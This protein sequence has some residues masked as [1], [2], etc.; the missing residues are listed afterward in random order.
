MNGHLQ[1][2]FYYFKLELTQ[3]K[4]HIRL[5]LNFCYSSKACFVENLIK[6][7]KKYFTDVFWIFMTFAN[8]FWQ[9]LVRFATNSLTYL[10]GIE[11]LTSFS[12]F[13]HLQNGFYYFKLDLTQ[14]KIHIWSLLSFCYSSEAYF[15]ENMMINKYFTD[16]FWLYKSKNRKIRGNFCFHHQRYFLET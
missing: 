12:C 16:V 6:K 10:A 5:L 9:F 4:I 8:W 13:W 11:F 1:N 14:I 15:V 2:G 3:I 7:T